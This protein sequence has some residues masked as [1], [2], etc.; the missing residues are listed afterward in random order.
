MEELFFSFCTF[1]LNV[2]CKLAS[3]AFIALSFVL[4]GSESFA[5]AR[6]K[7]L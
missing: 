1:C 4:S 7:S 3:S 2:V 6:T 5:P